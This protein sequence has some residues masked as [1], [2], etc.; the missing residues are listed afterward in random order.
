MHVYKSL[1]PPTPL[2]ESSIFTHVLPAQ[3]SLNPDSAAFIDGVTG[4][5]ITRRQ[6]RGEA[7]AFAWGLSVGLSDF[8]RTNLKRGD[9]IMVFSPNDVAYPLI[10]FGAVRFPSH[11]PG[12]LFP[13][14]DPR[15][16]RSQQAYK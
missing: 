3:S 7:L 1:Y 9:R 14:D 5:I 2:P 13:T 12:I 11:C 15:V 6:F 4:R 8:S 10:I 16:Y